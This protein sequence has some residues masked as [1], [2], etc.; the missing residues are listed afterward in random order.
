MIILSDCAYH[1]GIAFSLVSYLPVRLASF[2]IPSLPL[3]NFFIPLY[4]FIFFPFLS[5]LS[6]SSS[7][8]V[9]WFSSLPPFLI[10]FLAISF[11]LSH[12]VLS[13][14]AAFSLFSTFPFLAFPFP[15]SSHIFILSISLLISST[16]YSSHPFSYSS[17]PLLTHL[18]HFPTHLIHSLLIS[19]ISLLITCHLSS[20][21]LYSVLFF[22][23]KLSYS[24][25]F[26]ILFYFY[27]SYI[28]LL[29]PCTY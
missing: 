20:L 1:L 12:S 18:I 24:S 14:L 8:S 13:P 7:P 23:T 25:P 15:F 3:E 17:H 21:L 11:I 5:L 26:L 9:H 6:A 10:F 22:Y 19:S 28:F 29:P 4:N 16:P 2:S 27:F